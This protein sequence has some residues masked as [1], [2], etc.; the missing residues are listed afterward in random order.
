MSARLT[1]GGWIELL[2]SWYPPAWAEEWDNSGLQIGDRSW[3]AE[4]ILVALDATPEV[5]REAANRECRLLVTHHPLLFHPLDRLDL[6]DAISASVAQALTSRVAVMACHTNADVASP[7]VTDALV[8]TLGLTTEG[9]LE[10]TS[11]GERVKLVTFVPPEATSRVLD[12]LAGAGAGEIGE[13]TESSFRVRGSGTF[14][15]SE[16]ARPT[17]G[18]KGR[19]NEV[20]EDRLEMVVPRQKLETAVRFLIKA[21][22]Y[23][24]V[25]YDVYPLVG[26]GAGLG[27][28]ARPPM[29]MTAEELARRCEDRLGLAR[30]AGDPAAMVRSVA[31]CGGSGASL[32]GAALRA[33]VDAFVT[34]DVKHHQ[35]LD[36]EAAG[37]ALID[38][39]HHGTER[40]FVDHLAERLAKEGPG[41][42]VLTSHTSTDPFRQR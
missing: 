35:A 38:A 13:Y 32:T 27:R 10:E 26:G 16:A 21:H 36:A 22:P 31:L 20:E 34:G 17:V 42:E 2:D 3:P 41:G 24:E 8:E 39:G 23:E 30:L 4:R 1:V 25:A 28:I 9:V 29:P 5:I 15:P 11:A 33:E 40:P 14:R 7:G 19:L 12:A 6:S 37:L 18:V